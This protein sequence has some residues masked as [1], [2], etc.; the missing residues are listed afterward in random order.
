[1]SYIY[2]FEDIY[3]Y[4]YAQ[5]TDEEEKQNPTTKCDKYIQAKFANFVTYIDED[6]TIDYTVKQFTTTDE[7]T[8][9]LKNLLGLWMYER[10]KE[11]KVTK[12]SALTNIV[13]DAYKLTGMGDTKKSLREDLLKVSS[14]INDILATQL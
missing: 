10:L 8:E 13:S 11:D 3:S 5:C 6:A 1:M 9:K 14:K 4:F 12:Y 2:D 7:L